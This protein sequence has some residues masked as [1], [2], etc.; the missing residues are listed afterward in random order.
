[1]CYHEKSFETKQVLT[2]HPTGISE[3]GSLEIEVNEH[4]EICLFTVNQVNKCHF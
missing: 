2:S 1:M 3:F 4:S